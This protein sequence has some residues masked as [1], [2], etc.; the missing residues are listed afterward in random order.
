MKKTLKKS[1]S[2]L[3]SLIMVFS[4]FA[5]VPVTASA[6]VGEVVA[7]QMETLDLT[8]HGNDD[9][10][11]VDFNGE[12]FSVKAV[13]D[14]YDITTGDAGWDFDGDYPDAYASISALSGETITKIVV[15]RSDNVNTLIVKANGNSVAYTQSG[16]DFTYDNINASEVRLSANPNYTD[17][18][19]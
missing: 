16:E 1:V 11:P 12:H 2:I 17:D 4:V 15:H 7:E 13:G 3:L 14:I 9:M 18:C 6:Q 5:M 10:L 19:Y 8:Q